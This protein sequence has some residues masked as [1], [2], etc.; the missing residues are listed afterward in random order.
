M[1]A[2]T[3]YKL[4]NAQTKEIDCYFKKNLGRRISYDWHKKYTA[5]SGNFV[6]NF[7][8]EILYTIELEPLLN[9]SY[10]RRAYGHKNII[11][12]IYDKVLM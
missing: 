6:V 1:P 3:Q 11:E 7:F 12:L 5:L 2:I 9:P 10:M 8:P 4:S